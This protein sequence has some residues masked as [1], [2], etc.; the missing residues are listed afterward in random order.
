MTGIWPA[1][2]EVKKGIEKEK[3]CFNIGLKQS[4]LQLPDFLF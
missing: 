2:T 4:S 3:D 1:A